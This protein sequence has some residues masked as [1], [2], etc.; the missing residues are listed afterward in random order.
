MK[1]NT[2]ISLIFL[3]LV[4]CTEEDS[5]KILTCEYSQGGS[6]WLKKVFVFDSDDFDQ[7]NKV[8]EFFVV[9][10]KYSEERGSYSDTSDTVIIRYEVTPT[11]LRFFMKDDDGDEY[12][13][14]NILNRSTLQLITI[15]DRDDLFDTIKNEGCSLEDYGSGVKI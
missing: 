6:D 2:L 13:N 9:E 8:A 15:I 5:R 1:F 3:V 10:E 11:S 4:G 7:D 12:R 14:P